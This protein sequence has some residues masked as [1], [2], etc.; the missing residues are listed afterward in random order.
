[1][2][3]GNEVRPLVRA[4]S[5]LVVAGAAGI[6]GCASLRARMPQVHNPFAKAP[7]ASKPTAAAT[8][9]A[10]A[11]TAAPTVAAS[12]AQAPVAT[13]AAMP[14]EA[15]AV[16][17]APDA[18]DSI[19]RVVATVDGDPITM[20]DV[21]EFAASTGNPVSADGAGSSEAAKAALKALIEAKLLEQEV[22]K[23]EDKV[24]ESEV[25]RYIAAVRSQKHLSD[26]QFRQALV[27][28][29][30]SYDDFR[31]RARMEV[32]KMAM[33]DKEV[34]DKIVIPPSEIEAYYS[35]HKDDFTV[36]SERL[37]IAQILIAVPDNATAAQLA[38]AKKKADSIHNRAV[39]GEDFGGLARR[40]SDDSSKN[41]RGE[42]G[43]FAPGDIN[44]A[45]LAAL[46][47]LKPGDISPVVRTKFGFHVLRLEDHEVPG[48]RP[49]ADVREEI[50]Q[51]LQDERAQ[52][53]LQTWVD[54]E[55]VKQH[56]VQTNL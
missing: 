46:R 51:K 38:V 55:L 7:A 30:I 29:G 36:K 14:T 43:W 39:R 19:D 13:P 50:R 27:Q 1:M 21:V 20:R 8:K 16:A 32:E 41:N 12:P 42:L 40:Y 48:P 33:I 34:R 45:I 11:S 54:T 23:Y 15:P 2:A 24:D 35:A 28:N 10:A 37:K 6:V 9:L 53:T 56:Y 25:D 5:L 4:A 3:S 26:E 44:D 17:S 31:K 52:D 49:L 18:G 47:P 22:K